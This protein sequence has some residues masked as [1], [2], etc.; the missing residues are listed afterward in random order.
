MGVRV[1]TW[2]PMGTFPMVRS[3]GRP[4]RAPSNAQLLQRHPRQVIPVLHGLHDR[5]A[6]RA[7]VDS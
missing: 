5:R 1:M 3:A 6:E 2:T 7:Q 4:D